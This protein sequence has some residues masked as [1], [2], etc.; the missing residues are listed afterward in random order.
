MTNYRKKKLNRDVFEKISDRKRR[1][2]ADEDVKE[3]EL[4]I[5]TVFDIKTPEETIGE[6]S[7]KLSD[8]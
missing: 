3:L 6:I 8:K 4:P 7:N 1:I 2:V 5:T